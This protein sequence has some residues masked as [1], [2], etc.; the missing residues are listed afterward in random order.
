[1][2]FRSSL[3][4]AKHDAD[5]DDS[6]A[7]PLG[8]DDEYDLFIWGTGTDVLVGT[9]GNKGV[10]EFGDNSSDT[11]LFQNGITALGQSAIYLKGIPQTYG[12]PVTLGDIDTTVFVYTGT[13]IID[14]TLSGNPDGANITFGG[15]IIGNSGLG[16]EN[17]TLRAGTDGDI[18]VGGYAGSSSNRL[19][20]F[21][22]ESANDVT[23]NAVT[24]QSLVQTDRKSTRL[25]SSH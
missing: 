3:L 8:Y 1:M 7:D 12:A 2:L 5:R 16:G 14:T 23:L 22:I 25:N 24:A 9:L 18:V 17:L 15:N 11:L 21:L 6:I 10:L 13:S 20:A 19:G 4:D